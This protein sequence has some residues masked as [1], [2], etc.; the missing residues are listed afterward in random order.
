MHR[1][2]SELQS[3][4]DQGWQMAGETAIAR[5]LH[6]KETHKPGLLNWPS[7]PCCAPF[8]PHFF[9]GLAKKDKRL[10]QNRKNFKLPN[11]CRTFMAKV[12]ARAS[13]FSFEALTYCL[14][15][16]EKKSH[17]QTAEQDAYAVSSATAFGKP[18]FFF[19]NK[20]HCFYLQDVKDTYKSDSNRCHCCDFQAL[21]T[22][23]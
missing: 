14:C 16:W 4:W 8:H 6:I 2:Q 21:H 15:Y 12:F 3:T 10:H 5:D 19:F 9:V 17:H 22:F 23:P 20:S 18:L 1:A 11:S 13:K 7:P